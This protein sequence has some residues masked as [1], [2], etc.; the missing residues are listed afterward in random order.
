[1][2]H[3]T[4]NATGSFRGHLD[5]L[6]EA[7][8]A[9]PGRRTAGGRERGQEREWNDPRRDPAFHNRVLFAGSDR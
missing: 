9:R 1:M 8:P 5:V 7:R 2:F 3:S 4:H 6:A